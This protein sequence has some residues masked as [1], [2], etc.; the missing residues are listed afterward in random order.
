MTD[1]PRLLALL[2]VLLLPSAAQA[3]L[4]EAASKDATRA[5]MPDRRSPAP[6]LAVS[7]NAPRQPP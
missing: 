1:H 6:L 5:C 4:P 7:L 3:G 2:V